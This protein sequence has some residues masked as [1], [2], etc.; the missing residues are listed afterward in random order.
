[1]PY[2][3][4]FP[5]ILHPTTVLKEITTLENDMYPES[6]THIKTQC[7]R[8]FSLFRKL[9]QKCRI[10]MKMSANATHM[11]QTCNKVAFGNMYARYQFFCMRPHSEGLEEQDYKMDLLEQFYD[12]KQI[13]DLVDRAEQEKAKIRV[14]RR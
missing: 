2:L 7:F 13:Q 4:A 1:M 10:P 6:W 8:G 12:P 3:Q 11:Q 14:R 9:C 5:R